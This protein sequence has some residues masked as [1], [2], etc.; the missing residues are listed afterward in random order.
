MSARFRSAI[1]RGDTATIGL[2]PRVADRIRTGKDTG[3]RNLPFH[4]CT[5]NAYW[6]EL[7]L[8]TAVQRPRAATGQPPDRS[9]HPYTQGPE[10]R[11]AIK[12]PS[13]SHSRVST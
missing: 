1:D 9:T 13:V 8:T 6:L 10:P 4:A 11:L 7:A 2:A 3:M 12:F 5:A